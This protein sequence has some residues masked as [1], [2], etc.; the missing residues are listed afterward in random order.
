MFSC[1]E[2]KVPSRKGFSFFLSKILILRVMGIEPILTA[3]KA[4]R[5]PLTDTRYVL[6]V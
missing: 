3:W 6:I 1:Q 4:D 5:L 2:Y